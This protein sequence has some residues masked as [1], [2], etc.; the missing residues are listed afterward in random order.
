ME[1]ITSNIY[2]SV[3][4]PII[5]ALFTSWIIHL[6]NRKKYNSEIEKLK[7][8]T[9]R[10]RRDFQP[11][12][13]STLQEIQSSIYKTKLEGLSELVKVRNDVFDFENPIVNGRFLYQDLEDFYLHVLDHFSKENLD[14]YNIF[15]TKYGYLYPRKVNKKLSNVSTSL[16]GAYEKY[17]NN[18]SQQLHPN[19]S[20]LVTISELSTNFSLAIESVRKDLHLDNTFIHDFIKK[21]NIKHDPTRT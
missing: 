7:E 3:V 19:E 2:T 18:S 17:V 4:I 16:Y 15:F 20:E 10:L 14:K 21:Y 13:L 11:Y 1:T 9:K 12:I 5:V 8:E 6:I